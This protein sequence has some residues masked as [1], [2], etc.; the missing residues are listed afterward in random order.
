VE[1]VGMRDAENQDGMF[2]AKEGLLAIAIGVTV[3]SYPKGGTFTTRFEL[4]N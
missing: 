1:G 3:C 2:G 4:K